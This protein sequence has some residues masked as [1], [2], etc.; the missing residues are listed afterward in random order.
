MSSIVFL[1]TSVWRTIL[2]KGRLFFLAVVCIIA[3]KNAWGLNNPDIHTTLGI[4]KS[5]ALLSK[6]LCR[7]S[8]SANQGARGFKDGY[9]AAAHTSGTLSWKRLIFKA[10]ILSLIVSSPFKP[11]S[12][13]ANED[14]IAFS[15]IFIRPHSW[16]TKEAKGV[17]SSTDNSSKSLGS[18]V[19]NPSTLSA[20]FSSID[21]PPLPPTWRGCSSNIVENRSVDCCVKKPIS[22]FG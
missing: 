16:R 3:V 20:T 19:R 5:E 14:R 7:R 2:S 21:M 17:G 8:R 4:D 6:C 1:V 13:S 11:R 22:A 10:S 9:A 15:R 18:E 12:S